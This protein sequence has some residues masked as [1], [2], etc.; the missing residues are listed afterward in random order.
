MTI[1]YGLMIAFFSLCAHAGYGASDPVLVVLL[2]VKNEKDVIIPTLESYLP[3]GPNAQEALKDIG[4]VLYDTESDDGTR[5]IAREFFERNGVTHFVI[6]EEPF[7]ITED[8]DLNFAASRNNGLKFAR[9][10]F[11]SSTFILFPDAEWY[12]NSADLLIDFCRAEKA[13]YE[14]R[15]LSAPPYY[16]LYIETKRGGGHSYSFPTPRLFLRADDVVF[17]GKIH[18]CPT[19]I[20]EAYVPCSV[21]FNLGSSESGQEKSIRRWHR[22]RDLL[23]KELLAEPDN[24]RTALYLG[25][26]ELWLGNLRNSYTYL[27]IRVKLHSFPEEDYLAYYKLGIVTMLLAEQEPKSFSWSEAHDYFLKAYSLRPHRAEPLVRIAAHYMQEDNHPVSYIYSKRAV[28]LPTPKQELLEV[29]CRLYDYDRWEL[30]SRSA[31]YFG[32]YQRGEEATLKA[33]EGCPN[34]PHLYRNLGLFW[35]KLS[36]ASKGGVA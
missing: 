35:D 19:K 21:Y 30:F 5:E 4:Y 27:K 28:E 14:A 26:T 2:M 33:I 6:K 31:W 10:H 11:P 9:S 8:G 20:S 25:L 32:D 23:L 34:F 29:E 24:P 16:H 1:R 18:E 13:R 3:K 15:T 12:L 17:E 7:V 22:D 36:V